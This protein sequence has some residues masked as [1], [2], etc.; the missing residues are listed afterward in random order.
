MSLNADLLL[1]LDIPKRRVSYED[2]DTLLYALSLGAGL[3]GDLGFVQEAGQRVVPTFGQNL[4]FDDSWLETA[5]I[6]LA[7]VVHAGLDLSFSAPLEPSGEA[8]AVARVVGLT[9]KGPG[10]AGLVHHETV[11]HQNGAPV[12]TSASSM[13]VRGGGGF[14]GSRGTQPARMPEPE[15]E[16]TGTVTVPTRPDQALLFRLL[17]DRNPLHSQPDIARSAGFDRPILHGAC[18]FGIACL[19]VLQEFCGG[20]PERMDGFAARFSGPVY[21]GE[22]LDFTFWTMPDGIAFKASA[23]ERGMPVLDG[24]HAR[25]KSAPDAG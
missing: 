8:E 16:P 2:R 12:F 22:S 6:D 25:L 9:D 20:H 24:G 19:T 14:G 13:F 1:D 23:R 7:T 4:A 11:I 17:G 15:G 3:G 5:G 21:P 18:T 10:K